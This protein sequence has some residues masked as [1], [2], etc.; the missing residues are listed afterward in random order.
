MPNTVMP[1]HESWQFV[2][3]KSVGFVQV[4]GVEGLVVEGGAFVGMA[5]AA[6]AFAAPKRA[7]PARKA[8]QRPSFTTRTLREAGHRYRQLTRQLS[9]PQGLGLVWTRAQIRISVLLRQRHTGSA[10]N[11]STAL[12][13]HF[14]ISLIAAQRWIRA[15]IWPGA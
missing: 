6:R 8:A 15:G 14:I 10:N 11:R 13:R 12:H 5:S 4:D 3:K 9:A 2:V 7:A 1:Y